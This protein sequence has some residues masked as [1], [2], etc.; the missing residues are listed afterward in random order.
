L[1]SIGATSKGVSNLLPVLTEAYDQAKAAGMK[2][3]PLRRSQLTKLDDALAS[4]GREV[5][6]SNTIIDM[7]LVNTADKPLSDVE[8]ETFSIRGA[9]EEA[10]SRYPFNNRQ[11]RE[12]ITVSVREDFQITAPRL[13]IIHVL[14]NLIKNG[15]YFVQRARKGSID[16]S[17]SFTG[18]EGSIVVH[19]TGAGMPPGIRSRIFER[20]YTTTQ[21]GQSAGIGLSFCRLVMESVGGRITCESEEGEFTTFTLFFPEFRCR[22]SAEHYG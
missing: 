19:D 21:T 20:F 9:V 18:G 6:Y 16:I 17:A 3:K 8:S 14:F 1:A 2:V 5:E 4:I 22:T 13:L 10:V 7:L 11:E 15:L 12:L